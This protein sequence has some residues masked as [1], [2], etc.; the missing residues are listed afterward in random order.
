M[1]VAA[2]LREHAFRLAVA[3]ERGGGLTAAE[4][5]RLSQCLFNLTILSREMERAVR[6]PADGDLPH[7]AYGEEVRHDAA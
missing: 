1:S 4:C 3:A 2:A 6:R 5:G 7:H